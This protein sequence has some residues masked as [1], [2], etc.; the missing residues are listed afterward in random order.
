MAS[1]EFGFFVQGLPEQDH[2]KSL[3]ITMQGR[4]R[5]GGWDHR[6]IYHHLS[7]QFS[8]G[9][10]QAMVDMVCCVFKDVDIP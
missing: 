6:A 3:Q 2:K 4:N 10:A 7:A 8:A 5:K 9:L 1:G